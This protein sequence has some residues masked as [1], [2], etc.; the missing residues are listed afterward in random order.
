MSTGQR[1]TGYSALDMLEEDSDEALALRLSQMDDYEMSQ[2][3]K[4]LAGEDAA[5]PDSRFTT[6]PPT[7]TQAKSTSPAKPATSPG[8][9]ASFDDT[10]MPEHS[11]RSPHGVSPQ[12]QAHT[13]AQTHGLASDQYQR[14]EA[15]SSSS[16]PTPSR[17]FGAPTQTAASTPQSPGTSLSGARP[18]DS[19]LRQA[20]G[21]GPMQARD[22]FRGMDHLSQPGLTPSSEHRPTSPASSYLHSSA[23][24][25]EK[26]RQGLTEAQQVF[27]SQRAE[28]ERRQQMLESDHLGGEYRGPET[29]TMYNTDRSGYT[30][31]AQDVSHQDGL[32]KAGGPMYDPAMPHHLDGCTEVLAHARPTMLLLAIFSLCGVVS[33]FMSYGLPHSSVGSAETATVSRTVTI[34]PKNTLKAAVAPV[35][36]QRDWV[37]STAESTTVAP[38]KDCPYCYSSNERKPSLR[39]FVAPEVP[40]TTLQQF[41]LQINHEQPIEPIYNNLKQAVRDPYPP[42]RTYFPAADY[43]SEG[44]PAAVRQFEPGLWPGNP[45]FSLEPG[46]SNNLVA[47]TPQPVY[48]PPPESA[49]DIV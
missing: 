4:L 5:G 13:Q 39:S 31:L 9:S 42:P 46:Y 10:G 28:M 17:F 33:F 12:V 30:R 19:S 18:V 27:E 11:V 26:K 29:S 21:F 41:D 3:A 15:T 32:M 44:Y 34:S 16:S 49:G 6:S 23:S 35:E 24:E 37:S 38:S 25:Q 8:L 22:N 36:V 43:P 48:L 47:V 40:T 20:E 1:G 7:S 45:G 14:P 2:Y